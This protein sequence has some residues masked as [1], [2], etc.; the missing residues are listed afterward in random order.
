MRKILSFLTA[1][2]VSL[3]VASTAHA[4]VYIP[5]KTTDSAGTCTPQDC[6]L[7]EAI[8]AA[9]AHHGPDVILIGEGAADTIIDGGGLDRVFDVLSGVNAE[10]RSLTIRNGSVAGNGG[11]LRNAGTLTLSHCIVSGNTATQNGSGGGIGSSGRGARRPRGRARR[12]CP[13][14]CCRRSC[15]G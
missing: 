9:N 11:G 2:A 15:S 10:L 6:S 14:R 1:S 4:A 5:T 7:R 3:A 8:L 13:P 12:R